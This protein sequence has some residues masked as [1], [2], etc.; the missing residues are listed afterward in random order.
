MQGGIGEVNRREVPEGYRASYQ[1]G[2]A[3]NIEP[4]NIVLIYA[5][6]ICEM[7]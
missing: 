7:Q 6:R 5:T 4:D 2:N 3:M 1:D